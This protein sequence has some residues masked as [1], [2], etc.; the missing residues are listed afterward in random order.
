MMS[1]F[2]GSRFGACAAAGP[3]TTIKASARLARKVFK[4]RLRFER[5]NADGLPRPYGHN[6]AKAQH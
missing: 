6:Q 1:V 3:A 2:A 5:V 4:R